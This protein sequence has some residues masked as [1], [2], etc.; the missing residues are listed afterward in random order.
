MPFSPPIPE[1]ATPPPVESESPPVFP[2]PPPKAHT[3]N[4]KAPMT[5]LPPRKPKSPPQ[6]V[7]Q[8][9]EPPRTKTFE[10]L[11]ERHREKMRAMQAPLTKAEKEQAAL[12]AARVRWERANENEKMA[13]TKRQAE[14]AAAAKEAKK[15]N[16]RKSAGDRA[17]STSPDATG[18]DS[19]GSPA[20][21]ADV[22]AN[23]PGAKSST[24]SKRMSSMKVESW[25]RHQLAGDPEPAPVDPT[26]RSTPKRRSGVPFP[27]RGHSHPREP[28]N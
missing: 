21:R 18:D 20:L 23:I 2:S 28:T 22:L 13:V 12:E 10:E 5:I 19:R 14:Q 15:K 7:V 8:R 11:A 17:R 9:P 4:S 3:Q 16:K 26:P 27:G 25:Q 1:V 24:N 6:P